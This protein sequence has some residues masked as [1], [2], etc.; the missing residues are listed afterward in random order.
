MSNETLTYNLAH[1]E[2]ISSHYKQCVNC[3]NLAISNLDKAKLSF[4]NN[5]KGQSDETASALY[6]KIKEHMEFLRD[7][8]MQMET[9]VTYT[10]DTMVEVDQGLGERM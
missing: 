9:Y 2:E 5:Y 6:D 7:C 8:F 3:T 10:K 4:L 1:M